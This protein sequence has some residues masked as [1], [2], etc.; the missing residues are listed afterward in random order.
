MAGFIDEEVEV[1]FDQY[2]GLPVS[3]V[4][5]RQEYK[6]VQILSSWRRLDFKPA[7]WHRRHRDY[8]IVRVATGQIFKLYFNRSPKDRYWVLYKE[9]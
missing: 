2:P 1:R 9:L 7:W 5:R 8:L 4:W 6:I 3:F